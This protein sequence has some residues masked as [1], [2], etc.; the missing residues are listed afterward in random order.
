[1]DPDE[2][3]VRRAQKGD[4]FAFERLVA[5]H[6]QRM[7]TLAARVLGS[8]E[9]AADAV[10]EALVRAWLA[11]PRFRGDAR[12]STWFYRIIVHLCLDHRRRGV[13]WRRWLVRDDGTSDAPGAPDAAV[14]RRPAPG[15][16][17]GER[18]GREQHRTRLWAAVAGLSPR[19]R[20]VIVLHAQEELTT[21]EI[22]T[23]LQCAEATVR[24]HLHR[25]VSEL[26]RTLG[27][28]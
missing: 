25:A 16:D 3:L 10:Q 15:E 28:D 23:V 5:E 7:Y 11:L 18:L 24:V 19:Q 27:G 21:A 17:P 20:A 14:D 13:W 22:A 2:E 1:M 4:R 6:E 8:R 26:R 9:D 12:F